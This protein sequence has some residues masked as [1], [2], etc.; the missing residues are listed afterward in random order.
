MEL[1]LIPIS[2]WTSIPHH[3]EGGYIFTDDLI[4]D[5]LYV[6]VANC[7]GCRTYNQLFN[8][9]ASEVWDKC[10]P[11]WQT[12]AWGR[13]IERWRISWIPFDDIN[14]LKDWERHFIDT[15]NPILN[16]KGHSE[17]FRAVLLENRFG[18]LSGTGIDGLHQSRQEWEEWVMIKRAYPHLV[19]CK[20][21]R[22]CC[23]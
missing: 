7:L 16:T 13:L 4:D 23:R 12:H 1:Q 3:V 22:S 2:E 8:C 14:A 9:V 18:Y 5:F 10:A 15:Y 6:G 11:P 20:P 19:E 21:D 17:A